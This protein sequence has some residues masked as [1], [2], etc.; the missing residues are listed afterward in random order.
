MPMALSSSPRPAGRRAC[1][2]LRPAVLLA[3]AVT[4][5]ASPAM[6][7]GRE[8]SSE[9]SAPRWVFGG[10]LAASWGSDD[11]GYF[12]FANYESSTLRLFAASVSA[13]LRL[14]PAVALVGEVRSENVDG[15]RASALFVRW[16]PWRHRAFDVQ[17]GRIPPIFGR[18]A[19]RGYGADNPLIGWPVA[20][21]YLT[22]LRPDAV[23][24]SA[25]TLLAIRGRGWLANYRPGSASGGSTAY[26]AGPGVVAAAGVPLVSAFRWDTGVQVRVGGGRLQGALAVTQGSLSNPR[27]DDD[28][29]GKQVAGRLTWAPRPAVSLG[30]SGAR[31]KFL[32]DG[33]TRAVPAGTT[34]RGHQQAVGLDAEI[35]SGYWILRS[36]VISSWWQLPVISSPRIDSAL[37]ATAT[38]LE[39]RYRA[40]PGLY[41]AAR[42]EHLAFSSIAGTLFGG[43]PTSWDAPVSR[44]EAGLGYSISR[45][46]LLK[47]SWQYNQRDSARPRRTGRYTAVQLSM[48][49]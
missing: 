4:A 41:V 47:T 48:W 28:N 29:A 26:D 27:V 12:N 24:T 38:S 18:Y 34:A 17:A 7:Q 3:C 44:F 11:P 45:R 39:L 46:V 35:S 16:R 21:Q 23:P 25:D 42:G 13:S 32:S 33:A 14:N 6:G 31:G 15:V 36:E 49:F 22:T 8:E 9:P 43:E 37:R 20:Y 40:R 5:F 30:V 1:V 10:E 19:R 2:G